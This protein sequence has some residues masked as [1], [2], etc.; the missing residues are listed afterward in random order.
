MLFCGHAG[1]DEG[2]QLAVL[3]KDGYSADPRVGE[4][5]RPVHDLR[6]HG[7]EVFGDA[8]AA[9]AEPGEAAP[10][11]FYL[12]F[13]VVDWLQCATSLV[14]RKT[15]NPAST[16]QLESVSRIRTFGAILAIW[17]KGYRA[18]GLIHQQ[19]IIR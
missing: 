8:E 4:G 18:L 17:A 9:L 12:P 10:Q 7:A 14:L 3:I 2:L 13:Q 11:G 16:N 6:Q 1:G 15:P 5:A 19:L